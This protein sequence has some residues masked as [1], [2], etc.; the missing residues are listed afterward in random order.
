MK[1]KTMKNNSKEMKVFLKR[2]WDT[3]T[4]ELRKQLREHH[5]LK[6]ESK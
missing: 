5:H 1:T 4:G 2:L 6:N 3:E